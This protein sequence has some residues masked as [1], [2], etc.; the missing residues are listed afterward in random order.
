M[1]RALLDLCLPLSHHNVCPCVPGMGTNRG[2]DIGVS[3]ELHLEMAGN[4]S[5]IGASP[6][7][8]ALTIHSLCD[9]GKS[10]NLSELHL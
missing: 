10:P 8:K 2:A 5:D 1:G 4:S 6:E 9:L 3:E 7:F